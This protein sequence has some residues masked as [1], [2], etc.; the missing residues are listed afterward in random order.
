MTHEIWLDL[1]I[2]NIANDEGVITENSLEHVRT[3]I[4]SR[5]DIN[6]EEQRFVLHNHLDEMISKI[7]RRTL[8]KENNNKNYREN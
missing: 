2:G 3:V 4:T 5:F 8:K 1:N 6:L 7:I